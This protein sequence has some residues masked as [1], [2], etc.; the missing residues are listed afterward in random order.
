[1]S[2]GTTKKPDPLPLPWYRRSVRGIWEPNQL[3]TVGARQLCERRVR[4]AD[5]VA[6]AAT[7]SATGEHTSN[8]RPVLVLQLLQFLLLLL[9]LL[10][11]LD[12]DALPAAVRIG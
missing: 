11:R 1:M 2:S 7:A 6:I 12:D 10:L 8:G 5:A 4:I 3:Y 9:Q